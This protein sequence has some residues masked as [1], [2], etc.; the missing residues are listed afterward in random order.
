MIN[1]L[2]DHPR[3][4]S[5]VGTG[6][7]CRASSCRLRRDAIHSTRMKRRKAGQAMLSEGSH[8]TRTSWN[9]Q[10]SR[11]NIAERL[12]TKVSD[13][14]CPDIFDARMREELNGVG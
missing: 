6:T 3:V 10:S 7:L 9:R 12:P 2:H 8:P 13:L 1:S 4:G 11:R 5:I 14:L